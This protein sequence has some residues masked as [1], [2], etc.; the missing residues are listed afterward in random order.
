VAVN[1]QADVIEDGRSRLNDADTREKTALLEARH[2]TDRA[3]RTIADLKMVT[4]QTDG[5]ERVLSESM[6]IIAR[7]LEEHREALRELSDQKRLVAKLQRT[8]ESG[9]SERDQL[10]KKIGYMEHVIVHMKQ[11]VT[12]LSLQHSDA[13]QTRCGMVYTL[14]YITRAV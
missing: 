5:R 6:Q 7:Q 2:L 4:A 9:T 14:H 8:Q 1:N 3:N 10:R 12:A 13:T 11:I